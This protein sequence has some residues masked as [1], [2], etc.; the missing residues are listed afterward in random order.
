MSLELM[1]TMSAACLTSL[2]SLRAFSRREAV[3]IVA[4]TATALMRGIPFVEI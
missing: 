4:M 1:R 3:G 2:P